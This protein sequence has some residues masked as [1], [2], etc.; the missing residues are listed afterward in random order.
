MQEFFLS[1][2]HHLFFLQMQNIYITFGFDFVYLLLFCMVAKYERATL[3][4]LPDS[5]RDSELLLFTIMVLT[6][7]L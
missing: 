6:F 1:G 7:L 2:Q 3:A 5:P 4:R